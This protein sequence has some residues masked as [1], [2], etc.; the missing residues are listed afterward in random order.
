M[1][2][3]K[4]PEGLTPMESTAQVKRNGKDVTMP[5]L[6][7][8]TLGNLVYTLL[9]GQENMSSIS[10]RMKKPHSWLSQICAGRT[11][12]A[13]EL[14]LPLIEMAVGRNNPIIDE[15]VRDEEALKEIIAADTSTWSGWRARNCKIQRTPYTKRGSAGVVQSK[16]KTRHKAKTVVAENTP[17][18]AETPSIVPFGDI[19]FI[20]DRILKNMGVVERVPVVMF[21]TESLRAKLTSA[22]E[23]ELNAIQVL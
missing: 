19:T 20:V 18:A 9:L 22:L 4:I 14:Y 15:L 7:S 12:M 23:H 3:S 11:E 6:Y 10:V 2:K 16:P 13:P 5:E 8:S 21:R 1:K 17:R